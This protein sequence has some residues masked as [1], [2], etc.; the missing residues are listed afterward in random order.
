MILAPLAPLQAASVVQFAGCAVQPAMLN[1]VHD[2]RRWLASEVASSCLRLF[3]R[4]WLCVC[5]GAVLLMCVSVRVCP[6][7]FVRACVCV[8]VCVR[9][10]V[11][12]R[13][14]VYVFWLFYVLVCL[15]L[16]ISWS[17]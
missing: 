11:L 1:S 17:F 14:H 2:V 8:C 3:V 12:V 13:M 7:T 10:V 5:G 15:R 6:C 16:I 4:A 9:A